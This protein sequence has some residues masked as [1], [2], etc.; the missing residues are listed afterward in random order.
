MVGDRSRLAS[1]LGVAVVLAGCLRHAGAPSAPP[2]A[3]TAT[4]RYQVSNIDRAVAFYTQRLGFETVK[5]TGNV[6]A[7]VS[8]GDL[9]LLLSAPG[10]TGARPMPDG[11]AQQPG[12]WNRIVLYVDDLAS[13]VQALETRGVRL[14]TAIEVVPGGKQVLIEDPDGNPIE[15]HERDPGEPVEERRRPS[16]R[17]P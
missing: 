4:V 2:P 12:G 7:V 1:V 5:R 15:L 6:F 13:T 17:K 11:R 10:G 14:R 8:H 9:R 16:Y 3:G